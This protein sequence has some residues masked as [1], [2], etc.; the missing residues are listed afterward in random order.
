MK[1]AVLLDKLRVPFLDYMIAQPEQCFSADKI[2]I[3]QSGF[4]VVPKCMNDAFK[5]SPSVWKKSVSRF[6]NHYKDHM[7]LFCNINTEFDL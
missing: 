6:A 4:F 2:E 5:D 7:P 1:I 3:L